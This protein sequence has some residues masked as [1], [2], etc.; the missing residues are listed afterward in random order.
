MTVKRSTVWQAALAMGLAAWGGSAAQAEAWP[1]AGRPIQIIVPAPGGSGTGDA[2]ARLLGE[3]L[4]R[5]LG[6][7]VVIDNKPGANGNIGAA[8]AAN[9][10]AD[11]YKLL[12]SWAGTLTV[13]PS[14]YANLAYGARKSF[15]PIG[16]VGD[17]PNILVVGTAS[18]AKTFAEFVK[19]SQS[20]PESIYY[21]ST[22]VGS[23]MHLAGELF[24]RETGAKIQH[25]PYNA[26]GTAVSNLMANDIQAMF[27]LVPGVVGLVAGDKVRALAVMSVKRS[28]ALPLV[29][30][31]VELGYPRLLSS[32]WFALLAPKGTPDAVVDRLNTEVN[33]I[34][35][36]PEVR[37]KLQSLGVTPLGGTRQALADLIAEDTQKW[38]RVIK[39]NGIKGF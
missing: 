18:P 6:S 24:V 22:G 33:H 39:E 15:E 9:A 32:T 13:N 36:D 5:R 20:V 14:L 28:E 38:A 30:T 3:Q 23:S 16:L 17:V 31:T 11:G 25:V 29:P 7:P 4:S 10:P 12:F 35:S 37:K 21:G 34:V 2:I 1:Q 8:A 27:Q 26:P 19:L